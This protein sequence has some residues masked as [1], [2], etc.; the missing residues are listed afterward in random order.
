MNVIVDVIRC[1]Y[2]VLPRVIMTCMVIVFAR[3]SAAAAV[4]GRCRQWKADSQRPTMYAAA[5]SCGELAGV[6]VP[7]WR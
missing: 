5:L 7:R 3:D 6:A 4:P 1:C 2:V